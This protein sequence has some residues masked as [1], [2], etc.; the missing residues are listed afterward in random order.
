MNDDALVFSAK[1]GLGNR[2]RA[3]VGFRAL[4]E[5]QQLPLL[6]HWARDGAC[7]AEFTDLFETAG[8]EAVRLIDAEEAAARKASHPE[9]YHYSSVWFTEVWLRHGQALCSCDEFSRAAVKYLRLLRPRHELQSR[10][11]EFAQARNLAQ[12]T[13]LHIRM[14]DN[15]H[16]YDWWVK[17]DPH[18]DLEKV[19]QIEGFQA[20]IKVL[21]DKGERAFLCTDNQEIAPRLSSTF[22]NLVVYQKAFDPQGFKH[23]V[24]THYSVPS[25]FQRAFDQIKAAFGKAP[26]SSWRTTDVADALIEMMLLSRC[27]QVIGTYY[28]SFSQVSA[29]I[30]GIPLYR[31]EGISAVEDAFIR[32]LLAR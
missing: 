9:Q 6:L 2:L 23:H 22:N 7:D 20:A 8:W 29:L 17:N 21:A 24:R 28:S 5:F 3:L 14:T 19:S 18:F 27:K 10:V 32:G 25:R 11:D 4:A 30:G 26:P 16:S 15:V 13:G 12:C 31:M 1:D